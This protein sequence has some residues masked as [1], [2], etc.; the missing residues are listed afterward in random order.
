MGDLFLVV[1]PARSAGVRGQGGAPAAKRGRTTLTPARA[2]AGSG[3][4]GQGCRVSASGPPPGWAAGGDAA[5]ARA[6]GAPS[7][8]LVR[9]PMVRRRD[10]RW[11]A[12]PHRGGR[13]FFQGRPVPD[14]PAGGSRELAAAHQRGG[15]RAHGPHRVRPPAGGRG[16]A[17]L[18]RRPARRVRPGCGSS[19]GSACGPRSGWRGCRPAAA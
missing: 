7:L 18:A 19:G 13:S 9:G 17:R 5:T 11:G 1:G 8:I 10:A 15:Q 3:Q 16:R 12:S 2:V 6:R 14:R 4:R